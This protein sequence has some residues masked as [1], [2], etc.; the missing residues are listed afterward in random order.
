MKSTFNLFLEQTK[1]NNPIIFFLP[2]NTRPKHLPN[3]LLPQNH[4]FWH[5]GI[6]YNDY[7]YQLFNFKKYSK[8]KLTKEK[9]NNLL[10]QKAKIISINSSELNIKK[11]ESE[12]KSGTSCSTYVA[13]VLDLDDSTGDIKT[14]Y[15]DDLYEKLK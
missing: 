4:K 13:R 11:L 6:I 1:F 15:P 7:I 14:L 5:T 3:L 8:E 12:L 9:Y 2:I 10:N